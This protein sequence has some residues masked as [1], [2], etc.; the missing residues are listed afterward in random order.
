MFFQGFWAGGPWATTSPD[1]FLLFPKEWVSTGN[2]RGGLSTGWIDMLYEVHEASKRER[3]GEICVRRA[4][5]YSPAT[6]FRGNDVIDNLFSPILINVFWPSTRRRLGCG[7]V[8]SL[9]TTIDHVH[10]RFTLI[11]TKITFKQHQSKEQRKSKK[12]HSMS[13]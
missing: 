10:C 5:K 4:G 3:R 6:I 11:H 8:S 2:V 13:I 7:K 9:S 1:I 12:L